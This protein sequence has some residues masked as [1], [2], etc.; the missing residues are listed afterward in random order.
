V[1]VP[2]E[3]TETFYAATKHGGHDGQDG[4][5]LRYLEWTHPPDGT[6]SRVSFVFLLREA[7]GSVRTVYD[8]HEFGLF[9]RGTWLALLEDAGFA[10]GALVH[11]YG[12]Q[13]ERYRSE[14]FVGKVPPRS[15]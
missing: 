8:E 11:T 15:A 10:A 7:D 9:P 1:F 12:A 2:D 5:A 4:R 6:I 14:L 3:T 13:D